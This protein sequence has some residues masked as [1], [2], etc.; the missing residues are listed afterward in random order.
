MQRREEIEDNANSEDDGDAETEDEQD[1]IPSIERVCGNE[2]V[3]HNDLPTAARPRKRR[4]SPSTGANRGPIYDSDNAIEN[5]N[6]SDDNA[7]A[8][9]ED[10]HPSLVPHQSLTAPRFHFAIPLSTPAPAPVPH[11]VLPT[12]VPASLPAPLPEVFSPHRRGAKYLP[13]GLAA[14]C[15]EWVLSAAQLGAGVRRA[16]GA[17]LGGGEEAEWAARVEVVEVGGGEG[18]LLVRGAEAGERW[19]LLGGGSVAKGKVVGVKRPVW[20]V[21]VQGEVWGVGVEWRVLGEG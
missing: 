9:S 17:G 2:I 14:T 16:E 8:A 13:A 19:M 3:T 20:E 21:E 11:F 7:S 4:R 1:V 15:R 12:P 18:M 10:P 5:D 6:S